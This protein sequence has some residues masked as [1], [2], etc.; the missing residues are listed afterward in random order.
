M[1]CD[2]CYGPAKD[3]QYIW[4]IDT[5]SKGCKVV[6]LGALTACQGPKCAGMACNL[7]D[8]RCDREASKGNKW[9]LMD[10]HATI[11]QRARLLKSY[12]W[13]GNGVRAPAGGM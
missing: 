3:A 9:M 12:D 4:A 11:T 1:I 5:E 13:S 8:A 2:F 10:C 6:V 7:V